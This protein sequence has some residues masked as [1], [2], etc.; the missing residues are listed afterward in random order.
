MPRCAAPLLQ[1]LRDLGGGD[2]VD[3]DA[4]QAVDLAL[5]AAR[6]AGAGDGEPG[7]GERLVALLHDAAL[8]GEREDELGGRHGAAPCS[9]ASRRSVWMEAPTAGTWA[10][11]S[12]LGEQAVV[13][14]AAGDRALGAERRGDDLEHEARVVLEVAA[15]LGGELGIGDGDAGPVD[16]IEPALEGVEAGGEVDA[17][18]ARELRQLVDGG[19]RRRLHGDVAFDQ[20]RRLRRQRLLAQVGGLGQQALGDLGGRAR[21]DQLVARLR[22]GAP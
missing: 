5:V 14:P 16:E 21:A 6:G 18:A 7:L 20:R 8:G 12:D 1:E 19:A 10:P 11:A 3:L 15:E 22:R 4:G 9:T 2:E 17:V 13:A